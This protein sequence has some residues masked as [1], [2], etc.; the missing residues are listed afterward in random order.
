[1]SN[2]STIWTINPTTKK[3]IDNICIWLGAVSVALIITSAIGILVNQ[4][5]VPL[6]GIF[7]GIWGICSSLA[8]LA[9]SKKLYTQVE[10][11]KSEDC[12]LQLPATSTAASNS[13]GTFNDA[14]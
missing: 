13:Q 5:S 3:R 7:F 4:N 6:P 11:Q 14:P 2:V 10:R 12:Y 1:M 9:C 8:Y